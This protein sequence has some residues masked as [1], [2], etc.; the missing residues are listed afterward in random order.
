VF[1]CRERGKGRKGGKTPLFL[2]GPIFRPYLGSFYLT[3]RREGGGERGGGERKKLK[4][5]HTEP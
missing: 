3:K 1:E 4:R 2:A 5:Y